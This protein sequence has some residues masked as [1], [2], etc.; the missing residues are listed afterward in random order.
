MA[1]VGKIGRKNCCWIAIKEK[2][3]KVLEVFMAEWF[4]MNQHQP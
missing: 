3:V 2:V 1:A 4:G